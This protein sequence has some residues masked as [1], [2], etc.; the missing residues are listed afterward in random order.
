MLRLFA[1][2]LAPLLVP[3]LAPLMTSPQQDIGFLRDEFLAP[4]IGHNGI[5]VFSGKKS[6]YGTLSRYKPVGFVVFL[7]DRKAESKVMSIIAPKTIVAN[8]EL[9]SN[10]IYTIPDPDSPLFD[11]YYNNL[12][13]GPV[14]AYTHDGYPVVGS[15]MA[16]DLYDGCVV[17]R[18]NQYSDSNAPSKDALVYAA[19]VEA[20]E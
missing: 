1:K 18:T 3:L 4:L 2:L 10:R 19:T 11:E 5:T 12:L 17:I 20:G 15:L 9:S 8:E 7:K 6:L 14:V 13:E 16:Y